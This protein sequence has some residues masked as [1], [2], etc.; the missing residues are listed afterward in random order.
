MLAEALPISLAGRDA[1]L[2]AIMAKDTPLL[3]R[4]TGRPPAEVASTWPGLSGCHLV[5]AR[6][7]ADSLSA[8]G[9]GE[10]KLTGPVGRVFSRA[11]GRR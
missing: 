1:R 8:V 6:G 2:A 5:C 7:E 10:V 4:T 9:A 3:L 11:S